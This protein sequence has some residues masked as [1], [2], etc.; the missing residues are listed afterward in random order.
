M[1]VGHPIPAARDPGVARDIRLA[2]LMLILWAGAT[3]WLQWGHWPEDLSALYVAGHL[4]QS[5][6]SQ[7]IYAAPEGFF[8][9]AADSWGPVLRDLGIADRTVFS[10]VYPPL[11]AAL[12]APLTDAL[13]PQ[14]F[15]NAV[16]LI[17]VPILAAS[18]PL[19]ARLL[20]PAAMPL[21]VW[22]LLGLFALAFS[23]QS[24]LA[25]WH[26]QPSITVAFLVL[27][28]FVCAVEDRPVAAGAALALAAAVKLTPAASRSSS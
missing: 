26:N 5:G 18:V 27:V 9:G 28:A 17:Q 20:R 21:A 23:V 16:S 15:A 10:Y 14:G 22:T 8:G 4:W 2:A 11:W 25:L 7:L 19:A 6:H 1:D 13:G 12:L 3:V 24:Y